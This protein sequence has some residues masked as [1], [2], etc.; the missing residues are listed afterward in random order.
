[1]APFQPQHVS[2]SLTL[3]LLV[4]VVVFYG[5]GT[6][7]QRLFLGP[8]ARFPGPRLAALTRA[9]AFVQAIGGRQVKHVHELHKNYGPI[10]RVGPN[11]L[12]LSAPEVIPRLYSF[13]PFLKDPVLYDALNG[14]KPE[15]HLVCQ[16]DPETHARRRKHIAT[17][18]S[19]SAVK[20]YENENLHPKI[21]K[22]LLP[23]RDGDFYTAELTFGKVFGCLD[24]PGFSH[25]VLDA[26]AIVSDAVPVIN[27]IP[28]LNSIPRSLVG[29]Q[30][31]MEPVT[32]LEK[33]VADAWAAEKAGPEPTEVGH[34]VLS[35]LA[36]LL[37][38]DTPKYR[39]N[40]AL[41]EALTMIVA[42][43][44]TTTMAMV[45]ALHELSLNPGIQARIREEVAPLMPDVTKFDDVMEAAVVKEVLRLYPSVPGLLPR[46][47]GKDGLTVRNQFIPPGT[48]V[49]MQAWTIHR[50]IE[51]FPDPNT[52][53]PF[54]WLNRSEVELKAMTARFLPF[55]A[56]ARSC[57]GEEFA[58]AQ[59]Y[60]FVGMF[61]RFCQFA[62]APGSDNAI[63]DNGFTL[64]C[65]H[66]KMLLSI[67]TAPAVN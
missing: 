13:K 38:N 7:I 23:F 45:S 63:E 67:G 55:S 43:S 27:W 50:D 5:A 29:Y 40:V 19:R 8:L 30:P 64:N 41:S 14:G 12:S 28:W 42:C 60:L 65:R 17:L 57:V 11:D 49:S 53:N 16:T 61:C 47:V 31:Q 36:F 54:R 26:L 51:V 35:R 25:P 52:F 66:H 39:D 15:G 18:L 59:M 10:V 44:E 6:V 2:P 48:V 56:G 24:A 1:M 9:W 3:F 32:K 46:V 22:A 20:G 37:R 62:P 4:A 58:M 34:T 21:I 33:F